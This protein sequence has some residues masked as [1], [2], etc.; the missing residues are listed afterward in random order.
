M[1]QEGMPTLIFH[2][3]IGSCFMDWKTFLH[4]CGFDLAQFLAIDTWPT[5]LARLDLNLNHS[6][7]LTACPALNLSSLFL[8]S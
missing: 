3:V 2:L 7:F 6:S 4:S 5:L 1:T 8:Y